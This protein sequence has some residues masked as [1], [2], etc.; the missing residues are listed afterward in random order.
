MTPG[1]VVI[2]HGEAHTPAATAT[3]GTFG[4]VSPPSRRRVPQPSGPPGE[5]Q[6][7]SG[8][9]R[10]RRKTRTKPLLWLLGDV[11]QAGCAAEQAEVAAAA[12][13]GPVPGAALTWGRV[14]A[15]RDLVINSRRGGLRAPGLLA[16]IQGHH[17]GSRS[18]SV[19]TGC[20]SGS[21]LRVTGSRTSETVKYREET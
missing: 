17:A 21:S 1:C 3:E 13:R 9:R 8:A 14:L 19:G 5:Y 12:S 11:G 18:P 20:H 4:N 7:L 10:G 15:L 16:G 6:G 2:G